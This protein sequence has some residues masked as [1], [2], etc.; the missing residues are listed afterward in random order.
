MPDP[1]KTRFRSAILLAVLFAGSIGF[2]SALSLDDIKQVWSD[3]R[4][5]DWS[6]LSSW[7]ILL[8]LHIVTPVACLLLGFYVAG[9]RAWD[10]KAWLLLAVLLTFSVVSDGSDRMDHVMRWHTPIKHLALVYRSLVI[11]AWPICMLLFA[12]YFPERAKLDRQS[13]WLKW[14]LLVPAIAIYTLVVAVRLWVNESNS[15]QKTPYPIEHSASLLH[16]GMISVLLA[17]CLGILS[18]KLAGS[19]DHDDRR[20]L[21]VLFS[22]LATS[23]VPA[24]VVEGFIRRFLPHQRISPWVALPVYSVLV[25]FPITLAYVTVVQRAMDVR[26][27]LRQGL[28]YALARRGLTILQVGVSCLIILLVALMSGRLSFPERVALTTGGIGVMLLVGLTAR[29]LGKWVDRRFFR[30]AHNTEQLLA[31]LADTAGSLVEL[32]PLLTMVTTRIAEALHISEIAVFLCEHNAYRLA[33]AFGYPG[34]PVVEFSDR[35][36]TINELQRANKAVPV[37]LD[38][39]Q[40]W[41][42]HIDNQELAELHQLRTQLLVPLSRRD[43]L[44]GFLSLGRRYSEAPYTS[45]DVQLLQSVAQ[46]TAVAVENSRLT[47]TIA[48]EAAEREG[49]QRELSI[50]RDVQQRLLPQTFPIIAGL[51]CFGL[52]RPAREVGGDYYDFLEL[53]DEV[54]GVAIGDVAGKGIPASL[55]MASLQAS[56][57]GQTIGGCDNLQTLTRNVNQLVYAASPV[58]R[59]AT[60]FYAQYDAAQQQLTYVNAGHNAPLLLRCNQEPVRLD[61]GG[62]PVGLLPVSEYQSA[63]VQ[64]R[65]GDL[66]ILFTDGVSEAMNVDE[67]EWGEEKLLATLQL[68]DRRDPEALVE[69]VFQAADT[70]AGAAPQHD[71][72]TI[73][74]LSVGEK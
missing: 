52:C 1:S 24:V 59:Y 53:P 33:F 63:S 56:L 34:S 31:R 55:L 28:Q 12:I 13:P 32:P 22:G 57:R 67:E 61:V 20:R 40:S 73:V 26:V 54:L 72:M 11:T 49:L 50:A 65:S 8:N 37:Y 16:L 45:T 42:A 60:F 51:E 10:P 3:S 62:P 18:A 46:Q 4:H 47:S 29:R 6:M 71:D 17:A 64:L 58:N 15:L 9:V 30:E 14:T 36:P 70:F 66:I 5:F 21:R 68:N 23:F 25:L 27:I 69:A 38:D 44:L 39:P 35:S 7:A 43:E 48:S 19:K 41:T 74:I 2:Q